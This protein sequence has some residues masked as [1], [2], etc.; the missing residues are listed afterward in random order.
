MSK[1]II[2]EKVKPYKNL[3]YFKRDIKLQDDYNMNA[4]KRDAKFVINIGENEGRLVKTIDKYKDNYHIFDITNMRIIRNIKLIERQMTEQLPDEDP[5]KNLKIFKKNKGI[6]QI[7]VTDP[8]HL[9]IN[10]DTNSEWEY[11][12]NIDKVLIRVDGIIYSD[13]GVKVKLVLERT[14]IDPDRESMRC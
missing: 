9:I 6:L 8:D 11:F 7:G 10:P 12:L 14:H 2:G 13:K 5:A 4:E 1:V 3:E